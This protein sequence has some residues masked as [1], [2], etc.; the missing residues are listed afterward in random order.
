MDSH[1][2]HYLYSNELQSATTE[3][4]IRR[5]TD[6]IQAV[7][8]DVEQTVQDLSSWEHIDISQLSRS[9]YSLVASHHGLT[10][11]LQT[12]LFCDFLSLATN[13][14]SL[15][16]N[17]RI[18]DIPVFVATISSLIEEIRREIRDFADLATNL[19][20]IVVCFSNL[21]RNAIHHA[22]MVLPHLKASMTQL[23]IIQDVLD[24]LTHD[25]MQ[26]GG[27]DAADV[28]LAIERLGIGAFNFIRQAELNMDESRATDERIS[29]LK[30]IALSRKII[31]EDR[32]RFVDALPLEVSGATG[33]AFFGFT[34]SGLAIDLLQLEGRSMVVAG[35]SFSPITA[36]FLATAVGGAVLFGVVRLV[37]RLWQNHQYK[38]IGYLNQVL[39][40]LEKLNETNLHLNKCLHESRESFNAFEVN[41][42]TIRACLKS[43]RQRRANKAI[44]KEAMR[45]VGDM[46]QAL[47]AISALDARVLASREILLE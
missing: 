33:G 32:I 31:V 14:A 27:E 39:K 29:R 43:S 15:D 40:E 37:K 28:D 18:R 9:S 47:E 21:L 2:E 38:A 11:D 13:F 6:I 5:R 24:E 3:Q 46:I 22:R 34:A 25:D 12:R 41:I 45:N 44:C 30:S 8:T 1:Y 35:M 16:F 17:Q 7:E 26:L 19:D 42:D 20:E 23:D 36:L 10:N 4:E